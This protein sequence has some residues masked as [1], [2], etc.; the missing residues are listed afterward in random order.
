MIVV[1]AV[2]LIVAA[3]VA[4]IGVL[5]VT[6]RLRPNRWVGVR[7]PTTLRTAEIFAA[8]N[9]AAAPAMLGGAALFAIAAV[10]AIAFGGAIA[11]ALTALA[12]ATGV[13]VIIAGGQVGVRVAE[14]LGRQK[15]LEDADTDGCSGSCGSCTLQSTCE[16]A[17]PEQA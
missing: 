7:T 14:V 13:V 9:R 6:G 2:C 11:W 10:P 16:P 3:A 1:A 4:I 5:A 8:A 17:H 12:I 15:D